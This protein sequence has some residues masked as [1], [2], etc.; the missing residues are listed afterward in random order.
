MRNRL[1]KIWIGLIFFILTF[2]G[3]S[4][5]TCPFN[6]VDSS[7]ATLT[8]YTI[9]GCENLPSVSTGSTTIE[10]LKVWVK[11][12]D[13]IGTLELI[14]IRIFSFVINLIAIYLWIFFGLWI[15][16]PRLPS[17]P[18]DLWKKS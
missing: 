9:T 6:L 18:S 7:G 14:E 10:E 12:D 5:T 1:Y 16:R 3:V 4:A 11:S 13:F 15:T 2:N 17:K 8:G